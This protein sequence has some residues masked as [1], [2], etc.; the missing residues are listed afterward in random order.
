MLSNGSFRISFRFRNQYPCAD[1]YLIDLLKNQFDYEDVNQNNLVFDPNTGN[2][3]SIVLLEH[4]DHRISIQNRRGIIG[5]ETDKP[6]TGKK[7]I[8]FIY[9]LFE[10]DKKIGIDITKDIRFVEIIYDI[11]WLSEISWHIVTRNTKQYD[12]ELFNDFFGDRT[13][14]YQIRI[15]SRIPDDRLNDNVLNIDDFFEISIVPMTA[16]PSRVHINYIYRNSNYDRVM[17]TASELDE[18][19]RDLITELEGKNGK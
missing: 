1:D 16:N 10:K 18:K 5:I 11:K 6:E 17:E 4:E 12:H 13:Q 9:D 3:L 7:V 15:S 2:Q 19:L 14:N 8:Q